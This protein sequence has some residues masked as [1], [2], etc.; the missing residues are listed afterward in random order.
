MVVNSVSLTMTKIVS[1]VTTRKGR[2]SREKREGDQEETR[3]KPQLE[4]K[5][6]LLKPEKTRGP[7]RRGQEHIN[8]RRRDKEQNR[9]RTQ[10]LRG[11][12]ARYAECFFNNVLIFIV[13]LRYD[14]QF[15]YILN[16]FEGS[17]K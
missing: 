8:K 6:S 14:I 9:S 11:L 5:P 17:Y 7:P 1:G 3:T 2:Q 4:G 15:R 16:N 12:Q 10:E 13:A